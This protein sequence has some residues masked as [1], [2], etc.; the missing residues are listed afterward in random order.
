[1]LAQYEST[2]SGKRALVIVKNAEL[3]TFPGKHNGKKSG[4]LAGGTPVEIIDGE[5]DYS[6]VKAGQLEG[7]TP[8]KNIRKL[9][10]K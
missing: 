9:L 3:Y 5:S 1:M 4:T 10:T 7:W 8:N 6:L 2:Y